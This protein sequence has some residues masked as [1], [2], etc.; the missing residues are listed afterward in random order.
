MKMKTSDLNEATQQQW[1]QPEL[2][3]LTRNEPEKAA[4]KGCCAANMSLTDSGCNR[5]MRG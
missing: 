2:I 5:P 4:V 3:L 1:Q